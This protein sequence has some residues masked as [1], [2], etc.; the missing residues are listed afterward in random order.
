MIGALLYVLIIEVESN[1]LFHVG[2]PN[3]RYHIFSGDK[4][5]IVRLQRHWTMAAT[6]G[7]VEEFDAVQEERSQCVE[8]LWHFFVM[9]SIDAAEKKRS[10]FLAVMGLSVYKLL[11]TLV[12]PEKPGD[13]TLARMMTKHHNPTPLEMVQ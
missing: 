2:F 4:G 7:M 13:K 10:V 6:L 9:N 3:G 12:S 1:L 11:H 8:R 5:G